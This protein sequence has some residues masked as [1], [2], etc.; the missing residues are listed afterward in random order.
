MVNFSD[1]IG[2]SKLANLSSQQIAHPLTAARRSEH[3]RVL[4]A[5]FAPA[6]AGPVEQAGSHGARCEGLRRYPSL[7]VTATAGCGSDLVTLGP[8]PVDQGI[9]IYIHADFS[10]I[11]AGHRR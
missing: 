5:P 7:L 6:P 4:P 1:R 10:G 8:T 3:D 9:V 2:V 11:F